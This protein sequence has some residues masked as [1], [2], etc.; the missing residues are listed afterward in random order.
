MV[1]FTDKGISL[2]ACLSKLLL[3][4]IFCANLCVEY[5]C[6]WKRELKLQKQ[7]QGQKKGGVSVID[8]KLEE[9]KLEQRNLTM[10]VASQLESFNE[11][12]IVMI[13]NLVR[14]EVF[15]M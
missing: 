9:V 8:S 2:T 7:H 10:L 15:D 13:Q 5:R 3:L 11:D 4:I 1:A 6:N 12:I 14:Q